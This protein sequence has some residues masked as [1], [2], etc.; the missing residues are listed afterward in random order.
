MGH[1]AAL[2]ANFDGSAVGDGTPDLIHFGVGDGDAAFRPVDEAV[3]WAEPAKAVADA[4]NHDVAARV[5]ASGTRSCELRWC[6]I[7]DAEGTIEGAV[8]VAADDPVRSVGDSAISG[9]IFGT[10]PTADERDAILPDGPAA[11]KEC[12]GCAYA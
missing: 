8:F 11:S 10:E 4:V 12:E 1:P 9:V 3:G 6:G 2:G 7:A 5:N